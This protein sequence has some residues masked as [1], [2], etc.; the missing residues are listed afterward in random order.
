MVQ[1]R[2]RSGHVRLA[3]RCWALFKEVASYIRSRAQVGK[4]SA[5]TQAFRA[6]M[7]GMSRRAFVGQAGGFPVCGGTLSVVTREVTFGVVALVVRHGYRVAVW[8]EKKA[9]LLA[10]AHGEENADAT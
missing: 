4:H 7:L 6:F 3:G 8:K 9:G 10:M 1:L 5:C 2:A